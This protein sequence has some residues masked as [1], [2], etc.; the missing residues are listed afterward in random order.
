MVRI[1]MRNGPYMNLSDLSRE[2]RRRGIYPVVAA[3]AVGAWLVLQVA[4]VTFEP[5]QVPDW[6]MQALIGLV[7]IGF[8]VA[9]LL[10]WFFDMSLKGI[11]LDRGDITATADNEPSIAVLPFA[12]MSVEQDQGY[13][14]DG[15]AEE[16]LNAL[17]R[18]DQLHVAARSSSFQYRKQETGARKIGR[19]LAVGT[20]LEGSVRKSGNRVRI[21]AQLIDVRNGYHLWSKSFD[22]EL[23]DI[24]AIQD[25]IATGIV[26]A[27]L[28]TIVPGQGLPVKTTASD[29]VTAYDY[30][31]RGRHFINRFHKMEI[32]FA[33][34]M[35]QHAIDIDPEFALAWAGCADC[36][37]LL[38]IYHDPEEQYRQEARDASARALEL[39]PDLAEAHASRGLALLVS[40]EFEACEAAFRRAIE[41][42]PRLFQ[43]Y[44]YYA[45]ARFHQG[46][47]D[48]ALRLFR[49][50]ADVDPEDFQSRCLRVQILR[51]LDRMD[52]A[53][54]QAREVEP[55][56]LRHIEWN[57]DDA[58]ALHL[59]AGSMIVLGEM[60]RARRWMRRA[61]ERFPD[62]SVV[63][64]NLA[65][66]FAT[67]GDIEESLDFLER[68]VASGMV[69]AAWMRNDD[70][71]IP[72]RDSPRYQAL[73]KKLEDIESDRAA[74]VD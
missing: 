42:N 73:L 38:V 12:D 66:N 55:I 61:Y 31:L 53:L 21:T 1:S 51:G 45:R 32:D 40:E 23:K 58:R 69:G 18:I 71:L 4:E 17:A 26:E 47:M 70:D 49:L 34:Q 30:Y 14:C 62:D 13:F 16:I 10:A 29:N 11:R 65:C 24:F 59:G 46:D 19:D 57:P 8:P 64:Y 5:L 2:L 36:Y 28:E 25:D 39:A 67:M 37:S 20:I 54:E 48:D 27:L 43:A 63:L 6:V 50:A 74:G 3:Y 9:V 41:L 52:E 33:C 56:L 44:Y 68:S 60:E 7:I 35:F 22:S 72:L 15:V